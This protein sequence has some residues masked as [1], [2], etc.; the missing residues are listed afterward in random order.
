[1]RSI[2]TTIAVVFIA[3]TTHARA[4]VPAEL[5]PLCEQIADA[6]NCPEDASGK[7][8]CTCTIENSATGETPLLGAFR[9]LRVQQTPTPGAPHVDATHLV[10]QTNGGW[11]SYGA[12]THNGSERVVN[13]ESLSEGTVDKCWCNYDVPELGPV[14]VMEATEKVRGTSQ[15]LNY[16]IERTTKKV[17][18]AYAK[19]GELVVL[20][21]DAAYE[22]ETSKLNRGGPVPDADA[23][24]KIGKRSWKRLIAARDHRLGVG[25]PSGN[26]PFARAQPVMKGSFAYDELGKYTDE[27][28]IVLPLGQ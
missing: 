24:G 11:R 28:T 6:E 14:C 5:Q 1:M 10:I 27:V 21:I 25:A 22:E 16:Y 2:I 26:H 9:A 18:I 13:A 3:L 8:Q 7:T 12:V 4:E 23:Y 15:E 20:S 17:Y 19:G